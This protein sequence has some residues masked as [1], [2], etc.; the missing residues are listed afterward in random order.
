MSF[1]ADKTHVAF[2]KT[3]HPPA[4]PPPQHAQ[5]MPS[6]HAICL[7]SFGPVHTSNH[8][9]IYIMRICHPVA[10]LLANDIT[11][12]TIVFPLFASSSLILVLPGELEKGKLKLVAENG[13][14]SRSP[15]AA[16]TASSRLVKTKTPMSVRA[17]VKKKPSQPPRRHRYVRCSTSVLEVRP[18]LME[19]KATM[20]I[21]P[22]MTTMVP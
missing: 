15:R 12:R 18:L 2:A 11:L 13:A 19:P 1:S 22:R 17:I 16:R 20:P 14:A 6:V 21:T 8:P 7:S 9:V 3:R 5:P 4:S 10:M